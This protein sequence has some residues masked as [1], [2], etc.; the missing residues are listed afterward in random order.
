[1]GAIATLPARDPAGQAALEHAAHVADL[2]I[3]LH[4]VGGRDQVIKLAGRAAARSPLDDEHA[5]VAL[6]RAYAGARS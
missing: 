4:D 1:M 3:R 6:L 2:L 5:L